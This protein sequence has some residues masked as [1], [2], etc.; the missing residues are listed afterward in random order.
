MT[1]ETSQLLISLSNVDLLPNKLAISVI[2]DTSQVFISPY[3]SSA[4]GLSSVHKSTA[5][6]SSSFVAN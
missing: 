4:L 2:S 3:V 1:F 6:C 5:V